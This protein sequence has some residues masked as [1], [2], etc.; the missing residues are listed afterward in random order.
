MTDSPSDFNR[1]ILINGLDG[2]LDAVNYV[3]QH[4]LEGQFDESGDY[5]FLI[6]LTFVFDHLFLTWH[7]REMSSKHYLN[8]VQPPIQS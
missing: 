4:A 5:A 6:E 7:R 3:I 8:D 1:G 2:C